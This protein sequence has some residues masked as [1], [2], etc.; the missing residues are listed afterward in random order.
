MARNSTLTRSRLMFYILAPMILLMVYGTQ[1]SKLDGCPSFNASLKPESLR[2]SLDQ[3]VVLKNLEGQRTA[4]MVV[5]MFFILL[6]AFG[7]NIVALSTTHYPLIMHMFK[8]ETN[9]GLYS[10]NSYFFAQ[11]IADFPIEIMYP[12]LSVILAY[13]VTGQ[14]SSNFQWRMFAVAGS[15]CL[16]CYTMHSLGLLCGSIF[17]NNTAVALGVGQALLWIPVCVS[18]AF[19][20]L[21]R[22]PYWM[23]AISYTS[24]MRHAVASICAARYGFN[25]CNC[26][27]SV[28]E[29]EDKLTGAQELLPDNVKHVIEYLFPKNETDDIDVVDMFDRLRHRLSEAQS[30][31]TEVKTC[32]DVRPPVQADLGFSDSDLYL[33]P[34]Y[35]IIQIV[36]LKML[37][38]Y[39]VRS[40]PY[41]IK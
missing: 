11:T 22:L 4:G 37:T 18:G 19:L 39:S 38:Y 21:P 13:L 25:V 32:D 31:G 9:N 5:T 12:F 24:F 35:M 14:I 28:L 3:N 34:L 29:D 10:T 33:G 7:I 8:K 36:I 41:R 2:S 40:V 26:D 1:S 16:C 30:F 23:N 20:R 27:A 15:A 6:Y 17:I